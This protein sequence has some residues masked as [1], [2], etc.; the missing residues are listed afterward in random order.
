MAEL[1]ASPAFNQSSERQVLREFRSA[2]TGQRIGLVYG[3]KSQEDR[4][5]LEHSPTDQLGF[6]ALMASL[7]RLGLQAEQVD[8]TS[9]NFIAHLE[10]MDLLFLNL[11]GEYGEDG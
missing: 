10:A 11:H 5:Y 8:P 4:F 6:P 2:I 3:P 1:E 9:P 7:Q